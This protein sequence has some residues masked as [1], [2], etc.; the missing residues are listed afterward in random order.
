[1]VIRI[2]HRTGQREREGKGFG[3][4]LVGQYIDYFEDFL[5]NLTLTAQMPIALI[6]LDSLGGLLGGGST[7]QNLLNSLNAT[8]LTSLLGGLGGT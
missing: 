2:S 4:D 8:N 3:S 6:L 5:N 1:M 7:I